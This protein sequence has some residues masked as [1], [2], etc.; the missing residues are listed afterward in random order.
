MTHDFIVLLGR[1]PCNKVSVSKVFAAHLLGSLDC[2]SEL[3]IR[4]EICATEYHLVNGF[5]SSFK[6]F[7]MKNKVNV[8][9]HK[10]VRNSLLIK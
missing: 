5:F 8:I 4:K 7:V 6:V 10:S 2:S 9:G 1:L 3:L